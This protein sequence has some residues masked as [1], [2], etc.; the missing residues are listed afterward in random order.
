MERDELLKRHC[1]LLK[2][3]S[4]LPRK[5][6]NIHGKENASEFVLHELCNSDCFNLSKAAY[7][8]DN[9][10]FNC[11]KGVA[12]FCK[13]DGNST[14]AIDWN[15]PLQFTS[16]MEN[17]PFNKNVRSI[18]TA[19]SKVK[20]AHCDLV[21]DLATDLGFTHHGFCSWP[22]KYDNQGILIYQKDNL[23]DDF[24]EDHLNDALYL[25]S[26]CPIF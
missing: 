6:M 5:M 16:Y 19:S 24:I 13:L 12:G 1:T 23:T 11:L 4:S 17:S 26:F 20:G 18:V 3:I 10:D 14:V 7:F 8:I 2:I 22:M 21:K 25:L 9:P 15:N